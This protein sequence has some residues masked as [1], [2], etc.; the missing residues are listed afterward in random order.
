LRGRAFVK[1]GD[2]ESKKAA[3]DLNNTVLKGRDLRISE[4]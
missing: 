1:F 4:P 3:M 2:D